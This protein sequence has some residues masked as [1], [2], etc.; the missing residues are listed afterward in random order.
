MIDMDRNDASVFY[1]LSSQS[2]LIGV[3]FF[4]EVDSG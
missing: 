3:E 4:K 1:S 2:S